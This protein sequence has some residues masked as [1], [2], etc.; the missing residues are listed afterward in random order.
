VQTKTTLAAFSFVIAGALSSCAATSAKP[1]ATAVKEPSADTV[2]VI[3]E[4]ADVSVLEL[5][6]R[7][8]AGDIK[9]HIELGARYGRGRGVDLN[10]DKA[11]QLI[12]FAAERNDPIAEYFMGTAYYNGSGV[13]KDETAAALWFE[14]SADQ[15]YALAAFWMGFM[16]MN[17]RGGITATASGAVPYLWDAATQGNSL[18][19]LSL[20]YIYDKGQDVDRNTRAAAYWYRRAFANQRNVQAEYNLL[21]LIKQGEATWQPGDPGDAPGAANPAGPATTTSPAPEKPTGS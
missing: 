14:R 1:V 16:I 20:G 18:A 5:E 2:A 9:A 4:L 6:R 10:Y 7:V 3:P 19:A 12:K 15:H 8:A 21:L 11:I 13:P 17:G